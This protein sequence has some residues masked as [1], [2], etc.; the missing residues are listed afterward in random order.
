ML[1]WVQR[2]CGG[3]SPGWTPGGF[4]TARSDLAG[5]PSGQ[6][7]P[8]SDARLKGRAMGMTF[9]CATNPLFM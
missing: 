5:S 2:A 6:P 8:P 4:R 7:S 1:L 3:A 9:T